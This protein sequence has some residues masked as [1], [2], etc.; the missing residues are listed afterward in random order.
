MEA[1]AR[2][3]DEDVAETSKRLADPSVYADADLVRDL[4]ER[5]N[6]ARD[7]AESL[8]VEWTRLSAELEAVEAEDAMAESRR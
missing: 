7:R 3:A 5:H 1:E 2:H 6:E 4:I 8:A